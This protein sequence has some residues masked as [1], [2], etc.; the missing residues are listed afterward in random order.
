MTDI[1]YPYKTLRAEMTFDLGTPILDE[2]AVRRLASAGK[3]AVNSVPGL[4]LLA[5]ARLPV[6]VRVNTGQLKAYESQTVRPP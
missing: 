2:I 3:S 4:E 6:S 1:L 5:E